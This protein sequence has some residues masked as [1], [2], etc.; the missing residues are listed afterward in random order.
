MKIIQKGKW[1]NSDVYL[2]EHDSCQYVIKTFAH[3]PSFIRQTI[4]RFLISREYKALK[5]LAP[6]IGTC[7]KIIRPDKF[8]LSYQYINGHNLSS[9][10]RRNNSLNK[11]FFIDLETAVNEM[12][13]YGIV[14]LD[15]RTGSNIIISDGG[16]PVIIDFQSYLT[17]SIIPGQYLKNLLKSVDLSGVY[18]YWAK[19]SP[20]TLDKSKKERVAA[21]NKNRKMWF[22]KGYML[23]RHKKEKKRELNQNKINKKSRSNL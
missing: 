11:D 5:R 7:D 4:G 3:H 19:M 2:H 9:F 10:S 16:K 14:H 15:L 18:K 12:H 22:L 23:Q 17:L 1:G 8:T 13:S 6:C 20:E 21:L